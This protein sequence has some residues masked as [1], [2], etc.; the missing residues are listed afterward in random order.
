MFELFGSK[1]HTER[2]TEAE[3]QLRQAIHEA[4]GAKEAHRQG[5]EAAREMG[6]TRP[7]YEVDRRNR[8][9]AETAEAVIKA[10]AKLDNILSNPDHISIKDEMDR[11]K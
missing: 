10:Q 11:L 1:S 8:E 9:V 4:D 7:E 2:I 5:E 3:E 6:V